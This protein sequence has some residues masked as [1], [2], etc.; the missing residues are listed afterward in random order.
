MATPGI[1]KG[2]IQDRE[3]RSAVS[4]VRLEGGSGQTKII[5]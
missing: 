3:K 5:K 2:G 1:A 4:K